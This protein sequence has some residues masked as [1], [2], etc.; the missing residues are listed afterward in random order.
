MPF[1][2]SAI[3]FLGFDSCRV[4]ESLWPAWVSRAVVAILSAHAVH[5]AYSAKP[6]MRAAGGDGVLR[7]RDILGRA[8][9]DSGCY[10]PRMRRG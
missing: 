4:C 7:T 9:E 3:E 10:D 5:A 2:D 1:S 6:A 8:T